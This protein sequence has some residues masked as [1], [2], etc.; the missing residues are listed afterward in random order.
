[1]AERFR[2][3]AREDEKHIETLDSY[4]PSS[5]KPSRYPWH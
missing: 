2:D 3:L 4:Y 1:M 5:K